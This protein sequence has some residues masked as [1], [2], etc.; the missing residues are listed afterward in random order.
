M[1]FYNTGQ[2]L[3]QFGTQKTS[4]AIRYRCLWIAKSGIHEEVRINDE[5][6]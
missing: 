3:E 2:L 4:V 1:A 6:L 5:R